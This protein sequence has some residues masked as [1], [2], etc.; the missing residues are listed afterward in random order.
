LSYRLVHTLSDAQVDDLMS[1]YTQEWWTDQRTR[2]GVVDM[3]RHTSLILGLIDSND[4]L[5]AFC[6]LVTDFVYRGTLYDVI[7]RDDL[8]GCG[9]GKQLLDALLDLP[10]VSAIEIIDLTCRPD[11]ELLYAKWDWVT[12]RDGLLTMRRR[13]PGGA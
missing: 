11:K 7:V 13:R 6:R 4:R 2:E 3:L 9:L 5:V 1:L 12:Q 10:R 8:R